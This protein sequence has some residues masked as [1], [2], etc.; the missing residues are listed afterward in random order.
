MGIT[1]GNQAETVSAQQIAQ[2]LRVDAV[3]QC[4]LLSFRES[5]ADDKTVI[6]ARFRLTHAARG[7]SCGK[8]KLRLN[9]TAW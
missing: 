6:R 2:V 7:R 5:V 9:R 1:D 4:S 3:F 8:R